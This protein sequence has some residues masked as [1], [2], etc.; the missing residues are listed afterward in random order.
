MG[1][2]HRA[3]AT[4]P[5]VRWI[6]AH[7]RL[8]RGPIIRV[9]R[10]CQVGDGRYGL[11]FES[12]PP[13]PPLDLGL[14]RGRGGT[15]TATAAAAAAAAAGGDGSELFFYELSDILAVDGGEEG[16]SL[17]SSTSAETE[18]IE[19]E[20]GMLS[21]PVGGERT[22]SRRLSGRYSRAYLKIWLA[23]YRKRGQP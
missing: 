22:H 18:K 17:S 19:G 15:A 6:H 7:A 23:T 4:A 20:A 2:T 1:C 9:Y 14:G 5:S 11:G 3:S 13:P 12:P 16:L 21:V 8:D 10:V